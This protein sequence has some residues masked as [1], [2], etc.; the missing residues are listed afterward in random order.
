MLEKILSQFGKYYF[1]I[2]YTG[3]CGKIG[4]QIKNAMEIARN[5]SGL[6]LYIYNIYIN[7][8]YIY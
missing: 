6:N 8:I 5:K 3:D 1:V 4:M 7:L 2:Y